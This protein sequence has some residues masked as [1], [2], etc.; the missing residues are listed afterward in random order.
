[1]LD[2]KTLINADFAE[3]SQAVG[4]WKRLPEEFRDVS[5]QYTTTV[6]K[7]LRGSDWQGDTADAAYDKLNLTRKQIDS[8]ADEAADVHRLLDDA[9]EI[10]T[11]AQSRLKALTADIEKE[12]YLSIKPDGEVFIDLPEDTPA[13]QIAGI[14]KSYQESLRAY[15]DSIQRQVDTAKEADDVLYWALSQDFNGRKKGFDSRTYNS[16][17]SAKHGRAE[18]AAD[19]RALT[20]LAGVQRTYS[21]SDVQRINRILAQHEGDPYF[22]E[23]FATALGPQQTLEFWTRIADRQQTGDAMTKTS[24]KIQ[25]SL[26]HTLATASHSSSQEMDDWKR[27]MSRIGGRR[28]EIIDMEMGTS[29]TGPYGFQVMSSLMRNGDYD[30]SF[31][32]DYGKALIGFEKSHKEMTP[33]EL[34]QPE[35]YV[36]YLDFSSRS[37]H[38][39]DPMA[40][41]LEGLGHNPEAATAMFE[42]KNWKDSAG[43]WQQNMDPDLKYLLEDRKWPETPKANYDSLG[44]A[45]EAATLGIPYDHPELGLHRDDRTANVAEQVMKAVSNDP[46]YL[47]DRHGIGDSLARMGAGYIDDLDWAAGNFGNSH[48]D[49]QLLEST[50]QHRGAGH[51]NL[52]HGTAVGFLAQAGSTEEGYKILSIAQQEYTASSL[53]AHPEPNAQVSEMLATG[54]KMHGI[55]D[56]ARINSIHEHYGEATKE[57]EQKLADA[58]EWK[59]FRYGAAIGLGTAAVAL[60]FA[61]PAAGAAAVAAFAVPQVVGMGG[62]AYITDY[63]IN[64]NHQLEESGPN[65]SRKEQMD[66]M[67]FTAL[68]QGRA[69]APMDAY[70]TVNNLDDTQWSREAHA[71]VEGKYND[72]IDAVTVITPNSGK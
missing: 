72:G 3:L 54:A 41:Y 4:K 43:T 58:A 40:G 56:Q 60:P 7:G 9:H 35:G 42:A 70:I 68:G 2:Y 63:G 59:K 24:A 50:F 28:L 1:M 22:A 67:E 30:K 14:N 51:V 21:L 39:V 32:A 69:V 49:Q 33:K 38:G 25:Q 11:H 66:L 45:I 47:K 20:K 6:E 61:A 46:E 10:F 16:I 8:A 34:W 52:A 26:G 18:A 53:R 44:H 27:D 29:T 71:A 31:L 55:L 62:N 5:T 15:R 57:A 48:T 37:D 36:P 64:L 65:Y 19:L 13:E 17:K 23:K 12:K